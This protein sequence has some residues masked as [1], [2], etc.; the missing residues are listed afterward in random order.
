MEILNK[1][2]PFFFVRD[3]YSRGTFID[4]STGLVVDHNMFQGLFYRNIC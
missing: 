2:L 3:D 1:V 4:L